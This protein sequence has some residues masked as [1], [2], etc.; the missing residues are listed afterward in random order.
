MFDQFRPFLFLDLVDGIIP[1]KTFSPGRGHYT[2][3]IRTSQLIDWI[4]LGDDLITIQNS[5]DFHT[6]FY[7]LYSLLIN[8]LYT[9]FLFKKNCLIST[10]LLESLLPEKSLVCILW[11]HSNLD[12]PSQ[13]ITSITFHCSLQ[14]SLLQP[15]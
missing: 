2:A 1:L 15:T 4:V 7:Q 3:H 6:S 14:G 9:I 11:N 13:K 8:F 10:F 5:Q 12:G